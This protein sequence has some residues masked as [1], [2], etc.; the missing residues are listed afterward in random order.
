MYYGWVILAAIVYILY[1]YEHFTRKL[2]RG[3]QVFPE[4][5]FPTAIIGGGLMP[6][7]LFIFCWTFPPKIHWFPPI[8]GIAL[9]V[10]GG[11]LIFQTLF[12]LFGVVILSLS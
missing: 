12:N 6:L 10:I 7:G 1:F 5:F 3:K 4:I 2:L 11:F 9:Y 8:I